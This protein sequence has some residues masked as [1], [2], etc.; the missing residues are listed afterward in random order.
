MEYEGAPRRKSTNRAA[1]SGRSKARSSDT[2]PTKKKK[3]KPNTTEDALEAKMKA[4]KKKEKKSHSVA[5]NALEAKIRKKNAAKAQAQAANEAEQRS[6][7]H[8]EEKVEEDAEYSMSTESED[9]EMG[10]GYN[11]YNSRSGV[12]SSAPPPADPNALFTRGGGDVRNRPAT[13]IDPL[14]QA[15]IEKEEKAKN[16]KQVNTR[17]ADMHETGQWGGLSKWEKYGICAFI[18]AAIIAAIVLGVQLGTGGPTTSSPTMQPTDPPTLSPS[19]EPTMNPTDGTYREITGLEMMRAVSPKL[20][21]PQTPT[22]LNGA[23]TREDSTPQMLAAEF[24]LYNDPLE[25]PTRDARFMERYALVV[26]YYQNGGCSNDWISTTNW[27]NE[28]DHCGD[29][30]N[31]QSAWHGIECDL[32]KRIT[33]INLSKNY[34]TGKLPMEF[35]VLDEL[36]TLDLSNNAM[37]GEV[38]SEALSMRKLYT[39]QLNNNL[40]E[41]DFPFELVKGEGSI[42]CE[43][44][45]T[46]CA[47]YYTAGI[48]LFVHV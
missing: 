7:D 36:S 45:Y 17:Y 33:A 12:P 34:V 13:Q 4:K 31:P 8:E 9:E 24:I 19:A 42:L 47:P 18:L 40:L 27:M 2:S 5:D 6:Y 26:L 43:S 25:L 46:E 30:T 32:K 37:V 39:I 3:K 35:Q 14:R 1:G 23:S 48:L 28:L 15:E 22:E 21:L 10:S 16:A 38:P 11:N 20:T 41:G 29:G 44:Y